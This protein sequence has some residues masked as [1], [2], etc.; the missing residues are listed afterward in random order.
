MAARKVSGVS[1]APSDTPAVAYIMSRFPKLTETFIAREI[2]AV[3]RLGVAV[4]IHPL[5]RERA[6]LTHP[7]VDALVQQAHYQ[8]LLSLPILASQLALIATRPLAYARALRDVLRMTWGNWNFVLGALAFFPG[9]AHLARELRRRGVAHVHC[10]FATHPAVAG[11]VIHRLSGIP[12]SFTAHGSDLHRD[13]RGLCAK[14]A[15]AAVVITVSHFNKRVIVDECGSEAGSRVHVI[16]AGLDTDTFRPAE[17]E[18]RADGPMR[19]VC[20]GTLHEVKGQSHLIDACRLLADAGV[21]FSCHFIGDGPDREALAARAAAAGLRDRVH[22]EG[23][24][25]EDAVR[26]E[27][28]RATVL[29]APSVPSRDGRREGLPVVLMEA[30]STGVPVVASDLSGI[31]ELVEH[32]VTGLLVPP[33]DSEAIASALRRLDDDADLR[34]RLGAAGRERVVRDFDLRRNVATLLSLIGIRSGTASE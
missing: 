14:V 13:R 18:E 11:F 25:T 5:M 12:F 15:E 1:E 31:P 17:P 19:I 3:Q 26:A 22:L 4:E 23:A 21:D 29:V 27:L 28:Q 34:H 7:E 2:L 8:P 30:M 32:E 33:G 24:M 10:H 9:S 20:I 6:T 16:R